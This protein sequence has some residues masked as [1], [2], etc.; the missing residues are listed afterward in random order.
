MNIYR[1]AQLRNLTNEELKKLLIDS[2]WFDRDLL[3]EFEERRKDGRMR[4]IISIQ[5]KYCIKPEK[6]SLFTV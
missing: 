1:K 4:D 2:N 6:S 5:T 3:K